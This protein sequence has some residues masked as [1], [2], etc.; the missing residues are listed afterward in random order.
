MQ[1]VQ[2]R[3]YKRSSQTEDCHGFQGSSLSLEN[4]LHWV[5]WICTCFAFILRHQ[6]SG[7]LV[8]ITT[9]P[10]FIKGFPQN[11]QVLSIFLCLLLIPRRAICLECSFCEFV[12]HPGK[13]KWV[14]Y[15]AAPLPFSPDIPLLFSWNSLRPMRLS[16]WSKVPIVAVVLASH[17]TMLS[18]TYNW[19]QETL[20]SDLIYRSTTHIIIITNT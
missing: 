2:L 13:S 19:S 12:S 17:F 20:R 15:I 7:T 10:S 18:I 11:S 16:L 14:S 8:V 3:Q 6:S 1:L 4:V 5:S 9:S